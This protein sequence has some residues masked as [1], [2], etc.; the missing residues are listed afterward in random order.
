MCRHRPAGAPRTRWILPKPAPH[1]T[2]ERRRLNYA[3]YAFLGIAIVSEVIATS[4]LKASDGFSRWLPSL[5]TVVGYATAFYF[6]SLTM[7]SLPVGVVYATWS[8]VGIVLISVIGWLYY[9]E[10]L[11][12]PTVVGMALIV[13][14]VAVVNLFSKAH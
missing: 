13:V 12:W 9:R 11:N 2:A 3:N 1:P 14:G 4:A 10:S 8:G 6:L 7:K 5:V